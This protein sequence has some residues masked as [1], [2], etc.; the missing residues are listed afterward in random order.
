MNGSVPAGGAAGTGDPI[1]VA[2][3][4]K[5]FDAARGGF[6]ALRD[7]SFTVA[8]GEFLTLIGPSGCGKSTLLRLIAGL[9]PPTQGSITV[10]NSSPGDVRAARKFGFVFQDAV[11]LPWRTSLENIEL[12]MTIAGVPKAER[13]AKAGELLDLVGL[14]EFGDARPAKLSGGMARRVAI[15]RA[16]A[17]NPRILMLDEPFGA[18]DEITRQRLNVELQ[19]I[20]SAEK[21]T[22]VLVTHN[23][24]E[25]VFLSDRVIVMGAHPGRVVAQRII[26][27]PRP[28]TVEML[29]DPEFFAYTTQ[30][31]QLL[32]GDAVAA[33]GDAGDLGD[34]PA[35]AGSVEARG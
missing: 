22:T 7:V 29:A 30:L 6:T 12:P 19:R 14:S 11:L 31:S 9:I 32:L 5:T 2:G 23:V 18:L 17:L 35:L 4:S 20:W 13:Q 24:G 27:L 10:G 8:A 28:R 26:D 21:C 33:E 3:M 15:A 25:A 34:T 1:T 16:L